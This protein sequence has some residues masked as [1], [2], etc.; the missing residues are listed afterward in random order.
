MKIFGRKILERE[1]NATIDFDELVFVVG[2]HEIVVSTYT[3]SKSG[4]IEIRCNDGVLV[5][6]PRAANVIQIEARR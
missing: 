2:G 5:V 4:L 3:V 1:K 6:L